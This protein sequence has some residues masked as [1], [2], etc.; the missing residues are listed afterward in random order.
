MR[1][2]FRT[3][4]ILHSASIFFPIVIVKFVQNQ[5]KKMGGFFFF[6]GIRKLIFIIVHVNFLNVKIIAFH[7]TIIL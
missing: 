6:R 4:I 7:N 3:K 1:I 5:K 2:H